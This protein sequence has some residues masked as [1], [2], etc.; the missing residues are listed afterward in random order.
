MLRNRLPIILP[1]LVVIACCLVSLG[2]SVIESRV[3]TDAHHWGFMYGPAADFHQGLVPYRETFIYQGFLTTLIQSFSLNIFGNTVVSVGIVTGI[4]YSINIYLSYCLWQ[5]I[6]NKWLSSISAVLMFLVHGYIIY[7]WSNYFYYTFFLASLL[8]I[9]S[10]PQKQYKYLLAGVFAGLSLLARQSFLPVLVPL[11]LYFLLI[12]LVSSK[13]EFWQLH[14]KNIV[15]FHLG[16]I[17]IWGAFFLYLIQES[18]VRD[19]Y[20]QSFTILRYIKAVP[21][22]SDRLLLLKSVYRIILGREASM[23]GSSDARTILYSLILLNAI[24]NCLNIFLTARKKEIEINERDKILFLFSSVILLGYLNVIHLYNLF[25]LQSSS[26]LGLGLLIMSLH[27]LSTRFNQWKKLF[28]TV[29]VVCLFLYLSQTLVFT[30]TSSADYPWNRN[31]LL[32]NQL[33]HSENIEILKGKLFDENTRN[34]YQILSETMTKYSV[35]CQ[36]EYVVNFSMNSYIPFLTKSLKKVQRSP[37]YYKITE[38]IIFQDEKEKIAE[39]LRKEQAILVASDKSNM[40]GGSLPD[41][42]T[43]K[44]IPDNYQVV[45]ELPVPGIP[46]TGTKTY[47][48]VPKNLNCQN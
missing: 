22:F 40:L 14:F 30:K 7:P 45:L 20:A 48:A 38:D 36:L 47:I 4:F 27:N 15:A 31:L 11:Y 8:F 16:I 28:F 29:P 42:D 3:N 6:L 39:L 37:G 43:F 33:K 1:D 17:L 23:G 26:S 32:N 18:A 19:W 46:Y 10:S 2:L 24:I 25:R 21:A 35:S 5:K 9:T 44:Q 41:T 34:Y 13:K 12:F